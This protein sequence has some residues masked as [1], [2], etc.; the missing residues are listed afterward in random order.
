MGFRSAVALRE[1]LL[2]QVSIALLE[3]QGRDA[4]GERYKAVV[5]ITGPSGVSWPVRTVWIVRPGEDVARLVTAYP[6]RSKG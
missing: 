2:A 1:A 4:Y 6:E 3:P 5:P